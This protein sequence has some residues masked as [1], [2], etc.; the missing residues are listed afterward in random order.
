MIAGT[1]RA[2][3]ICRMEN[4]IWQGGSSGL[5][6]CLGGLGEFLLVSSMCFA[7][8]HGHLEMW[9]K[10]DPADDPETISLRWHIQV[11]L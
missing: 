11:L 3:S 7:I 4:W 9:L 2:H 8:Y 6:L 1:K 10:C 5:P